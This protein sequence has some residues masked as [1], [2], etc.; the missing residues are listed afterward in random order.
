[1]HA[2]GQKGGRSGTLYTPDLIPQLSH[3]LGSAEGAAGLQVWEL[4]GGWF[5]FRD[6]PSAQG[7]QRKKGNETAH[8]AVAA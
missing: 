1:M 4:I 8:F 7:K 6:W 3:Q 2:V 5:R